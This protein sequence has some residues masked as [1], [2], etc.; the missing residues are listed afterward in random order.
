[1]GNSTLSPAKCLTEWPNLGHHA[2]QFLGLSV[3]TPP[4]C[5]I[6]GAPYEYNVTSRNEGALYEFTP[7][8]E[9]CVEH[10]KLTANDW[11]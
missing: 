6:V 1:M 8:G 11:V 3:I 5:M 10:S 9:T 4:P 2:K 7:Q